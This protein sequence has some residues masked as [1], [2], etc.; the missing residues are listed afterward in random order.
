MPPTCTSGTNQRAV[1]PRLCFDL[2]AYLSC[3]SQDYCSYIVDCTIFRRYESR[4]ML[5]PVCRDDP[6]ASCCNQHANRRS[7]ATGH[8]S[9]Y[10]RWRHNADSC[11]WWWSAIDQSSVCNNGFICCIYSE[12]N[13]VLFVIEH[14]TNI[15]STLNHYRRWI[16][17]SQTS[18]SSS[19]SSSSSCP[20]CVANDCTACRDMW[21]WSDGSRAGYSSWQAG[22]P[23]TPTATCAE[24]RSD[25]LW[26][27]RP[28]SYSNP[29]IC[30]RGR[31]L[32]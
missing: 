25:G 14:D 22:H 1:S 32:S 23:Y 17:L 12:L 8:D 27:S 9:E 3:I 18:S 29:A 28:C 6:L 11:C 24:I 20:H 4:R 5:P 30:K 13:Y 15:D 26:Y 19:S 21:Q 31:Q 7:I 2:T 16:G 10:S